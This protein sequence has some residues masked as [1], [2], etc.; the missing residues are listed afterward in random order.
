MLSQLWMDGIQSAHRYFIAA[1]KRPEP[2]VRGKAFGSSFPVRHD[3]ALENN[4]TPD[5]NCY[6]CYFR[7]VVDTT[8][9][10]DNI[11]LDIWPGWH[12]KLDRT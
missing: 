6:V 3:R 7:S 11:K 12:K 9:Q 8:V 10:N 2:E 1:L 5:K 4:E